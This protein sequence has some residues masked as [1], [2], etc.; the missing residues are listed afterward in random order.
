M[1]GAFAAFLVATAIISIVG[2]SRSSDSASE[3]GQ[4]LVP[5]TV[6]Q[7][8]QLTNFQSF[9]ARIIS[10]DTGSYLKSSS[11]KT[12]FYFTF[13]LQKTNGEEFAISEN[14]TSQ[15]MFQ[16]ANSLEK[17]QIYIFPN[18]LISSNQETTAG[19]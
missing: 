18:V 11:A 19:N 13:I 15:R 14:P 5:L 16:I 6:Y 2:C 9:Q 7:F 10:K 17:G 12:N 3:H 1:R 4:L 8:S